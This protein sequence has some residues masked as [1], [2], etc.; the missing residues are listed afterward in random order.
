MGDLDLG[1]GTPDSE[2]NDRTGLALM[3]EDLQRDAV[4]MAL[5]TGIVVLA[6][7][8]ALPHDVRSGTHHDRFVLLIVWGQT[9]GLA[10]AHW[11]AFNLAAAGF[12]GGVPLRHDLLQGVV[13]VG[14]ACV[15]GVFTTIA[16]VL[17]GDGNDVVVAAFV[18]TAVIAIA[19]YETARKAHRSVVGSIMFSGVVLLIGLSIATLKAVLGH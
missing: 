19:G 10:L 12:R 2:F 1:R 15:I 6:T 7:L 16:M 11:F 5:Y 13:E 9:L 8:I 4:V 17:F 14:G 3:S 18:S